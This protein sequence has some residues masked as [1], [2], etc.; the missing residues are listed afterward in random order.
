MISIKYFSYRR[1]KDFLTFKL[2]YIHLNL[3]SILHEGKVTIFA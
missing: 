3:Q 2:N 1:Q